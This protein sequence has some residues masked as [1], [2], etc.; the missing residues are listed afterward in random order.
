MRSLLALL[1]ALACESVHPAAAQ[2]RAEEWARALNFKVVAVTCEEET[3]SVHDCLCDL[4][5]PE[6]VIPLECGSRSCEV[7]LR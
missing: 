1:L 2:L 3:C 7:R 4:R 5:T 6:G